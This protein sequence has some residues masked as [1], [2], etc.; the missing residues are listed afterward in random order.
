MICLRGFFVIVFLCGE[1]GSD[2]MSILQVLIALVGGLG[3][4]I[5]SVQYY[6]VPQYV[7]PP[8]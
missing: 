8:V 6:V 2:L 4:S 3:Y 1:L 7:I 5:M